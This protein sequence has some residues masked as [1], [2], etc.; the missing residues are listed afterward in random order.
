MYQTSE[1][2]QQIRDRVAQLIDQ[3]EYSE[4]ELSLLMGCDPSYLNKIV[5]GKGNFSLPK[6]MIFLDVMKLTPEEFFPVPHDEETSKLKPSDAD[7]VSYAF[8]VYKKMSRSA[9]DS[10]TDII[11]SYNKLR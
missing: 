4:R 6:L 8:D 11:L 2:G 3:T 9:Q 5:N 7:A 1:Y 10:F